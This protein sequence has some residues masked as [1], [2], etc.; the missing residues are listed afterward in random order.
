MTFE[1][2]GHNTNNMISILAFQGGRFIIDY[3]FLACVLSVFDFIL[4]RIP[5]EIWGT[6]SNLSL[7][8]IRANSGSLY[9]SIQLIRKKKQELISHVRLHAL[10]CDR[11][12]SY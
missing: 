9:R 2:Y 3:T 8:Q 10:A 6:N 5:R 1:Q 12:M 11:L 7:C 4:K